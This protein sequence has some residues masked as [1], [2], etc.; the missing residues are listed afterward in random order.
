MK[1]QKIYTAKNV[2]PAKVHKTL[3]RHI[4]ADGYDLVLDL[5]KSQGNYL[6]DSKSKRYLIDF[7][8]FF[9]SGAIGM[10]HPAIKEKSF[11]KKL[12]R[13][14]LHKPTNSDIYTEELATF[15]ETFS[16]I[17][18]PKYLPYSFFVEGGALAVENALKVAFDWK[19]QKNFKRGYKF[20]HG[21][22]VIHFKE[23]F[24]GR[25]GYTMSLTNTDSKKI[26]YF[27]KFNWPRILNP[28]ITFPLNDENL[29]KVIALENEA[30]KQIKNAFQSQKDEIAAIII[31][32]VQSEGGDN[33]FRKEFLQKLRE[34]ADENEALLIFD[35]V[36]TGVGM[37]GKMWVHEYFVKPDIIAFG[38][39][40]H[41][42]GISVGKRVDEIETNVMKI[43]S[44]LN[45]TFGGSLTDMVRF[46]KIMEVIK[47]E[48]LVENAKIHG[49][50]LLTKIYQIQNDFPNLFSN[51]RGLGLLC[52][53]D[54]QN[55]D[56]RDKFVKSSFQKGVFLLGSGD[57]TVRFRPQLILD[58]KTIDE[59]FEILKKVA[60][61]F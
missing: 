60:K 38:K 52:A 44:R 17:V 35:E 50:Y 33:H 5:E 24:H 11:Q 29:A 21:T 28:K 10:N 20:E 43:K 57:K 49:K 27:P 41:T 3:S 16:K 53:V 25:S 37:S 59:G 46:T 42:C 23:A 14:S 9:A 34:F 36:Q 61:T 13:A 45:S 56:T 19:V 26:K 22:Q 2:K 48:N 1:T 4:L 7:F 51:A 54:L 55:S 15:V 58:K 30:I 32:P 31:E 18:Q 12:L 39:K 6:Y 40:T 47:N 8:S